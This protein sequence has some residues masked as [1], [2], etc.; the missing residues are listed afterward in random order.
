MPIVP[1]MTLREMRAAGTLFSIPL[2]EPRNLRTLR[3]TAHIDKPP[4]S[5]VNTSINDSNKSV[6]NG[7]LKL[8][9]SAKGRS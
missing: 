2:P 6:N 8:G 7:A 1:K 3:T 9:L 4:A 5:S